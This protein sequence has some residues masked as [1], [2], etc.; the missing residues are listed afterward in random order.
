MAETKSGARPVPKT[1]NANITEQT[2]LRAQ[3]TRSG[4]LQKSQYHRCTTQR[5]APPGVSRVSLSG[6]DEASFWSMRTACEKRLT[7]TARYCR[8]HPWRPHAGARRG[9]VAAN[10]RGGKTHRAEFGFNTRERELGAQEGTHQIER[11]AHQCFLGKSTA[12]LS[13]C[14]RPQPPNNRHN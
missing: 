10:M 1:A 4:A 11:A 12:F 6:L 5:F 2:I 13:V 7:M 14:R 9:W 8:V 3:M